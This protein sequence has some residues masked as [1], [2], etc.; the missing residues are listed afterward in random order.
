MKEQWEYSNTTFVADKYNEIMLKF[1]PWSGHRRFGYDLIK[2]YEP[3]ILVELGSF[4]GCSSFAFMQAIKDNRL[5]TQVYPVDL[6]KAEDTFTFHDYE[7]DI[8][9]SFKE[10]TEKEFSDIAVTMMK[11]SF[12]EANKE[13][14]QQSINILHIDGSHAYADVKHDFITWLPKVKKDGIILFHDI[15]DQMLYGKTLGSCIFWKELKQ[16]YKWTVEMQYS[17]GLGILFLSEDIYKD[18]ISKVDLNYYL[19]L[20]TYEEAVCKDRIRKDYFKLKD[21]NQWIVSL[22]KD[23]EILGKDNNRLLL[24]TKNIKHD[25]ENNIHKKDN[26]I[27]QLEYEKIILEK[28]RN[29]LQEKYENTIEGKDS[30]INELKHTIDLYKEQNQKIKKDYEQTISKK[31]SYAQELKNTI[32]SYKEEIVLVKSTYEETITKKNMYIEELQDVIEKYQDEIE[33][34]K[35]DYENTI[36][37]K[38][39]YIQELELR[40]SK[41]K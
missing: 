18:F 4:Y 23:K 27:Q 2:Y 14:E 13:F 11:M 31:D 41:I 30:Y 19:K 1:S 21:A 16:Q 3:H 15:S 28:N 12:D 34:I 10:I 22:K 6:W 5:Q 40:L 37:G 17:W 29:A 25:Y 36:L 24:E 33:K 8:Y 35:K 39:S 7:Q 9:N 38:D 20:N 32:K 26:C